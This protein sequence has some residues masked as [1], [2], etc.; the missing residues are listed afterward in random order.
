MAIQFKNYYN[1][2]RGEWSAIILLLLLILFSFLIYYFYEEQIDSDFDLIGYQN[3]IYEFEKQQ[4]FLA[5]S[6]TRER[7]KRQEAYEQRYS[8]YK[9]KNRF[10]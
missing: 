10:N 2:S 8:R 9:K 6:L 7:E 4:L 3:E 1:F 5:D